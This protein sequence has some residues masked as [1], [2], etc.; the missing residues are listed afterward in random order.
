MTNKKEY[1][2]MDKESIEKLS[3]IGAM[4][5]AM[6][7]KQL[8]EMPAAQRDMMRGMMEKMIKSQMPKEMPKPEYKFTGKTDSYNGFDCEVVIKKIKKEKTQFCVTE[9]YNLGMADD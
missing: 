5:D 3:D 2:V 6:L 9:Y 7:E 1:F 4:M 8:A